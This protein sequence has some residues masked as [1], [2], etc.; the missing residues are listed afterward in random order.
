MLRIKGQRLREIEAQV[1]RKK[2]LIGLI[3]PIRLMGLIWI[4][5][6]IGANRSHE[7]H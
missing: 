4:M 5:G 7:A 1:V 6:L 3:G 2:R